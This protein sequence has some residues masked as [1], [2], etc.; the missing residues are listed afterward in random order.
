MR[1]SPPHQAANPRSAD[2]RTFSSGSSSNPEQSTTRAPPA[3]GEP[4]ASSPEERQWR[5]AVDFVHTRFECVL[6]RPAWPVLRRFVERRLGR[7]RRMKAALRRSPGALPIAL[8]VADC[9]QEVYLRAWEGYLG[10]RWRGA[11][12]FSTWLIGI[13]DKVIH[14]AG[15]RKRP[16]LCDHQ[17]LDALAARAAAQ[18]PSGEHFSSVEAAACQAEQYALLHQ[19]VDSLPPEQAQAV[20]LVYFKGLSI[21]EAA[22]CAAC[23]RRTFQRHLH[24]AVARLHSILGPRLR[25]ES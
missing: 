8:T 9:L 14:E 24:R 12:K 17:T 15:G 6:V 23:P 22:A 20:T 16:Q 11:G 2:Q 19:S 21:R 13:A 3:G 25:G 7:R 5:A 18:L 4:D 10:G 1:K